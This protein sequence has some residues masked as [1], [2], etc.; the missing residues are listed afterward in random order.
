MNETTKRILSGLVLGAIALAALTLDQFHFITLAGFVGLVALLGLSEF[1]RLAD[2]G[3]DGR[4]LRGIGYFFSVLI[5]LAYYAR[6]L[7]QKRAQGHSTGAFA[8]SFIFWFQ[9]G[10]DPV[11]FIFVLFLITA[12]IVHLLRR[13]LDGTLYSLGV[14]LF[15]PLYCVL[16]ICHGLLL[17]AMPNGL[18]WVIFFI[19]L[20]ISADTGGYFA[21]KFFGRHSAGL[22]VSPRKTYEGYFGGVILCT[23][24]GAGLFLGW[25]AWMPEHGTLDMPVLEIAIVSF[26]MAFF[27]IFGDLVESAFKRDA[28]IKDSASTIPGHGGVL[29]RADAIIFSLPLGFLYLSVRAALGFTY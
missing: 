8:D 13:P 4:P 3:L 6:F 10:F 9:P 20:P 7:A 23:L 11:P 1:Y 2:R 21:G 12:S 17:H 26:V 29:D 5:I 22:A 18:F 14:T 19:V 28:R 27:A 25:R 24:I 16:T 15:G